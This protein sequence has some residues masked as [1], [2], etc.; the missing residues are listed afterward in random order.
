[1]AIE[2]NDIE[3]SNDNWSNVDTDCELCK[4][5]KK[6]TWYYEDEQIIVSD[7][8]SGNPFV[9]QKNHDD[10][11]EDGLIKHAHEVVNELFGSHTFDTRMNKFP[12]HFHTHIILDSDNSEHLKK[13]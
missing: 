3:P 6:T 2:A 12:N 4:M 5:D 9:V 1:M 8:L 7:T 10:N 13:E 11:S